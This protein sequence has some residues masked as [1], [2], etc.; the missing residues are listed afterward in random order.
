[1]SFH[2]ATAAAALLLS[3]S[4]TAAA[5]D[6][7]GVPSGSYTVDPTH[8]YINFQYSHLGLS[9]PTLSFDDFTIDL[10]LDSADPSKSMVTVSID[11][12]SI[13]AGSELWKGHLVGD[14]FFDTANNPDIMFQS[15]SIEAEGDGAFKVMGDLTIKGQSKPMILNV[16][17]NAAMDHPMSG[18]PVIGL[19]A[20]GEIIRSDFGLGKFAPNV[21]DEVALNISAELLKAE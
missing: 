8:S 3:F 21:S 7:S 5:A 6:L 12:N 14:E 16:T 11:A 19:A 4:L 20:S 17:I 13:V 18:K 9:N 1:M 15:S 2:K 10:N